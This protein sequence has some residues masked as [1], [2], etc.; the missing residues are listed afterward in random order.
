MIDILHL[1]NFACYTHKSIEVNDFAFKAVLTELGRK[2]KLS[3]KLLLVAA[4]GGYLSHELQ[5]GTDAAETQ[6]RHMAHFTAT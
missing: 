1:R 3:P 6:L 2:K 5:M 4:V